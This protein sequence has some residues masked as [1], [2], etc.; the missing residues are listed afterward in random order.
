[1][2]KDSKHKLEALAVDGGMSNSDL[3]MQTQADILGIKVDRPVMRE[4]TALGAAIAAGFA[5]DI[6][7]EFDEL[8]E[9]NRDD[10]TIFTPQISE[11]KRVNMF[12]KWE[13]AV[14]MCRGWVLEDEGKED[15]VEE[16]KKEVDNE[17]A[18][19]EKVR[20]DAQIL[21][22]QVKREKDAVIAEKKEAEVEKEKLKETSSSTTE[23]SAPVVEAP[24]METHPPVDMTPPIRAQDDATESAST[25][26]NQEEQETKSSNEEPTIIPTKTEPQTTNEDLPTPMEQPNPLEAHTQPSK[27]SS[28]PQEAD[29]TELPAVGG[30]T[31]ESIPTQET[32]DLSSESTK[33]KDEKSEKD[34][35]EEV[36]ADKSQV[37]NP[38]KTVFTESENKPTESQE[39]AANDTPSKEEESHVVSTVEEGLSFSEVAKLDS[40]PTKTTTAR[41]NE[42]SAPA[43]LEAPVL[44]AEEFPALGQEETMPK[45]A[46]VQV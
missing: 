5:I 9:I 43:A 25:L 13:Q 14:Q 4:T 11:G 29:T 46:T 26:L 44:K 24:E 35:T 10:R 45:P 2:E 38:K 12:K 6:W 22:D 23:T 40:D 15:Q 41:A 3:T 27:Q 16:K 31:S 33:A 32:S 34:E 42:E 21:K 1:M 37:D 36:A 17:K 19:V 28:D 7:T 8:K 30:A 18:E 39:Q 20:K